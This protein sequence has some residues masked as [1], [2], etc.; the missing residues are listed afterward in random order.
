MKFET[1]IKIRKAIAKLYGDKSNEYEKRYRRNKVWVIGATLGITAVLGIICGLMQI[2]RTELTDGR[3]LSRNDK[4]ELKR[5]V[6]LYAM[7]SGGY[8]KDLRISVDNRKYSEEELND[9]YEPFCAELKKNIVQNGEDL[10]SVSSDM[11]LKDSLEGYPFKITWESDNSKILTSSGKIKEDSL[12]ESGEEIAVLTAKI[13]YDEYERELMIPIRVIARNKP[14]E[15]LFWEEVNE[16]IENKSQSTKTKAFQELPTK[17][18]GQTIKYTESKDSTAIYIFF[19]GVLAA[20]L[21]PMAEDEELLK[22]AVK[23]DEQL[24]RDYPTFISKIALYYSAGLP[25]KNIWRKMCERYGQDRKKATGNV[26][27]LYEEMLRCDKRMRDGYTQEEAFGIFSDHIGLKEYT[28]LINL[29]IQATRAGGSD[30]RHILKERRT[31]A[32]E[33]QKKTARVLGERAGT[34]LLIPMFMMLIVV[35]IIVLVPAF[36]SF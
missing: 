29:L 16:E 17:V 21:I 36:I 12:P 3:F 14:E 19:L 33:E 34:K 28:I 13:K 20:V 25:I 26:R 18:L 11:N 35:F 30:I 23:R 6:N 27:V 32:F 1:K 22:K 10:N 5:T 9:L 2:G 31:E 7:S 24:K 8:S 4:D 15:E